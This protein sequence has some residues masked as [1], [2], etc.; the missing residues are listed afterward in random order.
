[1]QVVVRFG[2]LATLVCLV[3]VFVQVGS[4]VSRQ[5][6]IIVKQGNLRTASPAFSVGRQVDCVTF[7]RRL[8][9][10]VPR[11]GETTAQFWTA[12]GTHVFLYLTH[13][14]SGYTHI[15]CGAA[16]WFGGG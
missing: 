11:W 14:S 10:N 2:F 8:T 9:V 16:K 13:F 3:G 4:A 1:M 15:M 5:S 12:N 6:P 7:G